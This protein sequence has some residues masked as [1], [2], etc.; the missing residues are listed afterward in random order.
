MI[1]P[2]RKGGVRLHFICRAV[3]A[4]VNPASSRLVHI[5]GVLAHVLPLHSISA[6][7]ARYLFPP[8]LSSSRHPSLRSG[9]AGWLAG[10]SFESLD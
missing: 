6:L 5:F 9:L 8:V 7:G 10:S 1:F 2:V 3:G 4:D